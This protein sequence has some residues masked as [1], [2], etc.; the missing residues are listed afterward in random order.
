MLSLHATGTQTGTIDAMAVPH[1]PFDRPANPAG[2]PAYGF[3]MEGLRFLAMSVLKLAGW[4][5]DG[6][7]PVDHK[8][9]V[10]GGPHTSN[11]DFALLLLCT[12]HFRVRT[13]WIGKD[14]LFKPPH[15][16]IMRRLGGISVDRSKASDTVSQVVD[17]YNSR[18]DLILVITPEGTRGKVTRWKSGFY[19]IAHGANVPIMIFYA[20]YGR[21]VCGVGPV[22][23]PTG[24]YDR[25][26]AEIREFFDSVTPKNPNRVPRADRQ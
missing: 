21:K 5:I 17:Y 20:D 10:V 11:W 18:D 14:A 16:W 4:R 2:W 15:G 8:M 9:M 23:V 7:L 3:V 19:W 6:Q 26:V 22:V 13:N 1:S 25:D 12:M 24:D